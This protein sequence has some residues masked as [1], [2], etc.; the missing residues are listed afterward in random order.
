MTTTTTGHLTPNGLEFGPTKS[1]KIYL[2][3]NWHRGAGSAHH[4]TEW[5]I[6]HSEEFKI[7][8]CADDDNWKDDPGNYWSI[9]DGEVIGKNEERVAKFP[10]PQNSHDP[11]HGYPV[12]TGDDKPP[13]PLIDLWEEKSYISRSLAKRMKKGK[14]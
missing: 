3:A 9:K 10:V 11:W 1:G 5:T 8:C 4:K 6:T 13:K 2:C 12:M 7:F 14:V